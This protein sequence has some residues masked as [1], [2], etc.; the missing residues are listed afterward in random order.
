MRSRKAGRVAPS[1]GGGHSADFGAPNTVSAMQTKSRFF[2]DLARMAGG[3]VSTAAGIKQEI[4]GLIHQRIEGVLA[5]MDVVPREEFDA[6]RDMAAK[7]RKAQEALEKRVATLESQLA[8]Q[9]K[10][11]PKAASRRPSGRADA[12]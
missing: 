12:D 4:E 10:A 7:A 11:K 9:T 8:E 5:R 2:E 1:G 6:V 3:A